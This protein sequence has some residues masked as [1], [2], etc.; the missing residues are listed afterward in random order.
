MIKNILNT[1]IYQNSVLNYSLS[2]LSIIL[3]III[4]SFIRRFIKVKVKQKEQ[5]KESNTFV[6]SIYSLSL[7][8]VF[9]LLYLLIIYI[10]VMHLSKPFFLDKI[11]KSGFVIAFTLLFINFLINIIKTIL[12]NIFQ[13][14]KNNAKLVVFNAF[15][16]AIQIILWGIG[17]I[18]LLD[19]IG[20]KIT[21]LVA[22]LGI[23]GVAV[24]L[25][26]QTILKDLFGYFTILIDKPFEIGDVIM[27]GE[28]IGTVEKIGLKTTR[29][30]SLGG[31]LLIFSNAD[32]TD[33]RIRNYKKMKRRRI[34]F[35]IGV[36]YET[37]KELLEEIP[38]I[39]EKAVKNVSNATFERAHFASFGDFSLIFEVVYYVEN[40]DYNEYMNIQQKINMNIVKSFEEKGISFAYPTQMI[41]V[42]SNNLEL[43]K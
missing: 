7:N 19:N 20:F 31:E 1:S 28:H 11:L 42:K 8:A 33:S 13:K 25:A 9:P 14:D 38:L 23:G 22:G 39:L 34:V 10:A 6:L 29:L 3:G 30:R 37:K 24:A 12:T 2:A 27:I 5:D 35:K 36:V 41:F 32:L 40:A 26:G 15:F 43:S 18:F 16:P 4:I 17:I 21:T